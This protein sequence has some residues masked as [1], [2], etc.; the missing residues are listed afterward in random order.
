MTSSVT[1]VKFIKIKFI[2]GIIPKASRT[3]FHQIRIMKPKVILVQVPVP[4][5]EKTKKWKIFL[6]YKTGQQRD[7]KSGQ[8][9]RITDRG[10]K[11]F[12]SGHKDYKLEHGFQIGEK[13]FQ[14]GARG[15]QFGVEITNRCRTRQIHTRKNHMTSFFVAFT[16]T[17][18]VLIVCLP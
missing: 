2:L 5:W 8:V 16:G 11:D 13:R 3:K 12:K 7:Y 15:I 10:K 14:I 4:K 9:L 1:R 18:A 6:G 17:A